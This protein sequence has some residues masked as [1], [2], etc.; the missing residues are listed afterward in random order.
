MCRGIEEGGFCLP[1][2]Q[3]QVEESE[4]GRHSVGGAASLSQP[5]ALQITIWPGG[6]LKV[7]SAAL[8]IALLS[9]QAAC[10]GE[11]NFL[12]SGSPLSTKEQVLP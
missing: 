8:P 12:R 5:R 1:A 4:K 9:S 10:D 3:W 2:P 6:C 7:R 11:V